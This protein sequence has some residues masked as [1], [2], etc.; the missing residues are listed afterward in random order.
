MEMQSLTL[1]VAM[2]LPLNT[3]T[4]N[5]ESR[6]DRWDKRTNPRIPWP[7]HLFPELKKSVARRLMLSMKTEKDAKQAKTIMHE[8]AAHLPKL[9]K[10][11]DS[12]TVSLPVSLFLWNIT[13]SP[14]FPLLTCCSSDDC[15]I[16]ACICVQM[17]VLTNFALIEQQTGAV[18]LTG[19]MQANALDEAMKM[20]RGVVFFSVYACF[21]LVHDV[22]STGPSMKLFYFRS[23]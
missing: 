4:A 12:L 21:K 18:L 8:Y 1:C 9:T 7:M 23:D 5:A 2:E 16:S 14:V 20:L 17:A 22:I 3:S 10:V 11:C 6:T 15:D 19:C 13:I